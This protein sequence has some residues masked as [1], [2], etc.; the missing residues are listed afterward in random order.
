LKSK[1]KPK[2]KKD[3]IVERH[4]RLMNRQTSWEAKL[5]RAQNAL[6]KVQKER[7]AYE[8]RHKDRIFIK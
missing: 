7:R 1:A 2:V 5:T 6:K 4:E 8:R 3:G